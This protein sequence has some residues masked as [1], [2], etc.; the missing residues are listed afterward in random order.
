MSKSRAMWN[1]KRRGLAITRL[2]ARDGDR[3]WICGEALDRKEPCPW[4]N[5]SAVSFDHVVP[6]SEGGVSDLHNL[7][8]AHRACNMAR[9]NDP[10]V[11]DDS[12]DTRAA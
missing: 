11:E 7:R 6:R 2:M 4:K 10:L 5:P 8:L 9:G 12:A 3:C 1:Q